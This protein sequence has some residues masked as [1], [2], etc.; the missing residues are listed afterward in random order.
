MAPKQVS[1]P[2]KICNPQLTVAQSL[3]FV[4]ETGTARPKGNSRTLI[5][6][7]ARRKPD[8]KT[9]TSSHVHLIRP[10][11]RSSDT[12]EGS[13]QRCSPFPDQNQLSLFPRRAVVDPFQTLPASDAGNAQFYIHYCERLPSLITCCSEPAPPIYIPD[14]HPLTFHAVPDWS[15]PSLSKC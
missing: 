10:R 2:T 12:K 4:T 13:E 15:I 9:K 14:F 3:S 5:R 8:K 7:H 11:D 6:S 1:A